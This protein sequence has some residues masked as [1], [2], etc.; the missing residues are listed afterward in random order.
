MLSEVLEAAAPVKREVRSDRQPGI[1]MSSLFPCPYR[2]Y[3]VHIGQYWGEDITPQQYYNMADG[4]D[5]EE[6]SVKRLAKAGVKV[7][8]RQKKVKV[9]RSG[10]PGTM[11]GAVVVNGIRYV[12][13]H[14]AYDDKSE[15]LW[16]M[17]TLG[18]DGMPSQKAQTNGYMLGDGSE[19]ACF[20]V[21]VK[22]NNTYEDRR[23]G[24][25]L[26]FIKQIVSWCDSIR[27]DNWVP[28]P[29]RRKWCS[30]C[31]VGCFDPVL[32]F[33]KLGVAHAPEMAERWLQGDKLEKVGEMMKKEARAF[34]VGSEKDEIEGII[35]DRDSL[36][37]DDLIEIKKIVSRRFDVSKQKVLEVF[38]PDGLIKVGENKEITQYR[39]NPIIQ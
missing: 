7:I 35:G 6:Q 20:F 19:H 37:V 1:S 12:W 30:Q 32:D 22:N 8:D 31:N 33:S 5:Q 21:K 39:F 26:S 16:E 11:D 15:S 25:D 13:E 18:F 24:I 36:I 27:L 14:K 3:K 10:V 9:G 29:Q 2:L 4:W 28:V 17:R 23:I 38:G 34:F